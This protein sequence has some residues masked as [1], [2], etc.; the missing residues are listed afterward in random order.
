MRAKKCIAIPVKRMYYCCVKI[1]RNCTSAGN[2]RAICIFIIIPGM[3]MEE[4]KSCL[5]FW[6]R[7]HGLN[8][9][10]GA[11]LAAILYNDTMGN[12]HSR[13]SQVGIVHIVH[14]LGGCFLT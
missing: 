9:R 10:R 2:T 7:Q 1:A 12:N 13:G 4:Q 3:G 11:G 5:R 14:Y 6:R 8:I